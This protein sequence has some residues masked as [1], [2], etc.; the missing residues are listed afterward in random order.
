M[1]PCHHLME[2][3][4][5]AHRTGDAVEGT[6]VEASHPDPDGEVGGVA[7]R[8]AIAEVGRSAG[9][10]GDAEGQIER[11]V[12]PEGEG[13]GAFVGKDVADEPGRVRVEDPA[14]FYLGLTRLSRGMKRVCLA[15]KPHRF[16]LAEAGEGGV[17]IGEF[18]E[19]D[20]GV[21]E[22]EAES[23]FGRG[24]GEAGEMKILHQAIVQPGR[25]ADLIEQLHRGYVQRIREGM[26]DRDGAHEAAAEIHGLVG[27]GGGDV[28]DGGVGEDGRGARVAL[29]GEGVGERLQGRSRGARTPRAVYLSGRRTEEG[30]RSAEGEDFTARIFNDDDGGLEVV[31]LPGLVGETCEFGGDKILDS[32]LETKIEGGADDRARCLGGFDGRA[33]ALEKQLGEMRRVEGSLVTGNQFRFLDEGGGEAG[34][35]DVTLLPHPAED[36][37]LALACPLEVLPGIQLG[38]FV[39]QSGE[40]GGL[41][42]GEIAEGLPEVAAGGGAGTGELVAVGEVVEVGGEDGLLVRRHLEVSRGEGLDDLRAEVAAARRSV[43]LDGLLGDGR[44][45]RDELAVQQGIAHGTEH[46]EEVDAAVREVARILRREGGEDKAL[47]EFVVGRGF[48]GAEFAIEEPPHRTVFTID[49]EDSGGCRG[50]EGFREGKE[51][52]HEVESG[53]DGG[54]PGQGEPKKGAFP[55]PKPPHQDSG[56]FTSSLPRFYRVVAAATSPLSRGRG[57]AVMRP[58]PLSPKRCG[59]YIASIFA[60]GAVTSPGATTRARYWRE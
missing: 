31:F 29:E 40:E 39:R 6:V 45:A 59:S 60:G 54:Q 34:F 25:A 37:E 51:P 24:G 49:E 21:A 19:T 58:V 33:F 3:R 13:A 9:L 42:E 20:L 36:P 55:F 30:A 23:V 43:E 2:N 44:G 15:E 38:W 27:A 26:T 1:E 50:A 8:P 16:P 4:G 28:F 46:A 12:E 47:G 32:M 52:R 7:D 22:G 11:R 5:R 35:V 57:A 41:G 10:R 48:V 53:E 17:A 18:E 56:P 14:G